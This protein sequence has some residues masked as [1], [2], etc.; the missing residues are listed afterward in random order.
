[1]KNIARNKLLLMILS[2]L[3]LLATALFHVYI[4]EG[5][6]KLIWMIFL[7]ILICF[8]IAH[9]LKVA[10]L[11][12]DLEAE[13]QKNRDAHDRLMI[14]YQIESTLSKISSKLSF[15][16]NLDEK[17]EESLGMLGE[18]CNADRAYVFRVTD[19]EDTVSNTHEWCAKDVKPQKDM[20]QNLSGSDYH[21]WLEKLTSEGA[22][23]IKD[24]EELPPEA[25]AEKDL[26]TS[27]D[28]KSLIALP[29]FIEN[30]IA[31]FIGFDNIRETN[32]WTK[33]D[34]EALNTYSNLLA[35]AFRKNSIS[36][37]LNL[38]RRQLLSIFDSMEEP[39]YVSDP[40]THE[41][42]YVNKFL[43][44]I[45]EENPIGK[46]CYHVLQGL[47][48]PCDF[49]TNPIILKNKNQTYK[50]EYH[51]PLTERDY[52]VMDRIIKWIDGNDV[53]L[54]MAHDIT[55]I[56]QAEKA[57]KQ[58]EENFIKIID[59]S[60]LPIAIMNS[61]GEFK[62]TNHK[63]SEMIGYTIEDIPTISKWWNT[64]YP[65]PEYRRKV[66]QNWNEVSKEKESGFSGEWII[67]CLD[68]TERQVVVYFA[69]TNDNTVFIINDLTELKNT[70]SALMVDESCLETLHELSYMNGLSIDN[71]RNFALTEGIKL[72]GSEAGV[73][74]FFDENKYLSSVIIQPENI[75]KIYGFTDNDLI[76]GLQSCYRWT[77]LLENKKPLIMNEP[78]EI[79]LARCP[80]IFKRM[81]IL[82]YLAAPI[83]YENDVVGFLAVANK[84]DDYTK[85]DARQLSLITQMMGD[86]I[87]LKRSEDELKDYNSKLEE[88]NNELRKVNDEL[89]SLDEMKS[90]FLATM[91]HELKTPLISIM[92]FGELVGD[93]TLG[94]LNKEQ[95]RA[96]KVV[97]SNSGQL[98]RLI[99]SLLF[100]SSLQAKNYQYEYSELR[101]SQIIDKALSI[102]SMENTDK[103]LTVENTISDSL[104]FVSGDS[105]YLSEVFIHLIDNAFKFTPSGGSISISGK[106]EETGI[107]IVI[108]DTGIG[109][110]DT[111]IMKT[112]DSFYQ[113]DG[114]LTRRY[115]GA[116]IGLN[117]CKR[118]TEDHGGKLWLESVEGMGTNVHV[119][120]PAM[121]TVLSPSI[122][123]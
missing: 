45:I 17:I 106:H 76:S 117:I 34:I 60:P 4:L 49:C 92:G 65:D 82:S 11:K 23:H 24:I 105:N 98:K 3:V 33:Q 104:P 69:K 89:H 91:S 46:K 107:H 67:R 112:F 36:E 19:G 85:N 54:E 75:L 59:N 101:L 113:L 68:G 102:I 32:E 44:Q 123:S 29:F 50:W 40:S 56:K 43:K 64:V 2:F 110:P 70:Q 47:N 57:I 118:I 103:Q 83:I 38:E 22:V 39:V 86:M 97:N 79:E 87:L 63:L 13:V 73:L 108:E 115:G 41:I 1:M 84:K 37:E 94:P 61:L 51:N 109:I 100:M 95:K 18:L 119:I 78:N 66:Q 42:L 120:L 6:Q 72:T 121:N 122:S 99:E 48:E 31:G 55:E 90:N 8:V 9:N 62:Y 93:E 52:L 12:K 5:E 15:A 81:N 88:I 111:K 16:D 10:T 116:G 27:Q 77:E 28:I 7:A 71:I 53:R 96:M 20:L 14:K 25:K 26:L 74:G 35:M 58:N 80:D 114:S 21:W 30:D